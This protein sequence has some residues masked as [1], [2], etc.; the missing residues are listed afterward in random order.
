MGSELGARVAMAA[1]EV[2]SAYHRLV[3]VV[4]PARSGKTAM[5][6]EVASEHGWPRINVNLSLS[7]QLLEHTQRSRARKV[8]EILRG[9]VKE[10]GAETVILDNL[11]VLFGV[12]LQVD[13]LRLLQN[14]SR[15]LTIVAAWP[16][17]LE[18]GQLI[19]GQTD[20]PEYRRETDPQAVVIAVD[21][22]HPVAS[23]SAFQA[24]G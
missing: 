11:E 10:R 3:I 12:D 22:E 8:S 18:N 7:E 6:D 4:G 5:L 21:E 17:K 24:E 14:I 1:A 15:N 2:K 9:L 19:Y 20:H 16:G 13:P 23:G